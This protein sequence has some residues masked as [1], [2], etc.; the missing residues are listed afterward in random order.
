M[1]E[2]CRH[3]PDAFVSFVCVDAF[4]GEGPSAV[5][6]WLHVWTQNSEERGGVVQH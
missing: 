5:L 4:S 6:L 3:F 2:M 1:L